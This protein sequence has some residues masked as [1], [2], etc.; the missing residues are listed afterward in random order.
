MDNG[1]L[2]AAQL[3][4]LFPLS[5]VKTFIVQ[6]SNRNA[7]LP[8]LPPETDVLIEHA[9]LSCSLHTP[10]T[11]TIVLRVL[12]GGLLLE[13]ISLST[14]LS[15]IRFA[16]PAV[17][18]SSPA[19]FLWS[20]HEIHILVVTDAGSLFRLV[21]PFG[22]DRQPWHEQIGG[23]WCREYIIKNITGHVNGVVQ[24]QG[25]HCVAVGLPNGSLL[26]IETEVLGNDNKPGT[27]STMAIL[28][29][30]D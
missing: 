7:P 18:V 28:S 19:I 25:T 4:S 2:V 27:P 15:P 10:I 9:S 30:W 29:L 20:S 26:R 3:S 8:S 14:P 23:N 1:I 6:T 5:Q 17:I 11:G 24:V 13:L 16:F 21:L 22:K 12:H